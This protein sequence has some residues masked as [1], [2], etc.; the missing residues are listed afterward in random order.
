MCAEHLTQG[1]VEQ[2]CCRV[3]G[4]TGTALCRVHAC[5]EVCFRMFGHLVGDVHADAVLAF[6]IDDVYR[7]VLAYQYA[8][9]A[10]LSAHLAI[11]RRAVEH[12]LIVAALLLRHL[13]VAQYVT[14]VFAVV[15]AH[16]LRLAFA[17]GNPVARLHGCGIACTLLL[18]LH[19]LVELLLVYGQT[20]LAAYQF[21][22]VEREAVGVEQRECLHAVKLCLAGSLDIGH[23]LAEQADALV[24]RAQEG[25]LFLLHDLDDKLALCFK[26]GICPSHLAYEH[27]HEL[28]DEC[29]FLSEERV[30]IA[31]GAAQ[32]AADDVACL[33]I[34]RQLSVGNGE[35]YGT[36]MVGNDTHCHVGLLVLAVFQS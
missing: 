22:E 30:G 16:K 23:C 13:A 9:V 17:Q 33:G 14:F 20:V 35:G 18:L 24:E 15:V 21:G 2:V 5:H 29:F 34:A 11:E 19:L 3:V 32:D 12:N 10:D 1:C 28:V 27:G 31:R 4:G 6:G 8:A 7:V 36:Q 25:V 26:L